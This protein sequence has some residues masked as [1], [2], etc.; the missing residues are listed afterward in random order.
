MDYLRRHRDAAFLCC[1]ALAGGAGAELFDDASGTRRRRR[2]NRPVD[3]RRRR[4]DAGTDP[5]RL[6]AGPARFSCSLADYIGKVLRFD[7]GY[8]FYYNQPVTHADL[9][10]GCPQRCC[11]S[12]P[13]R[14]LA[15]LIGVVAGRDLSAQSQRACSSHFVTL[16]RAVRLFRPGVLDRHPAAYRVFAED[17]DVSRSQACATSRCR[18]AVLGQALGH[19]AASWCCRCSTLSPSFWRFIRG[20]AARR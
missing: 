7:L 3:G 6:R 18:A 5:R 1:H 12:S 20:F 14:L 17:P 13:R 8:S 10:D 16:L 11:W 19:R 15:L 4:G 9:R 2:H